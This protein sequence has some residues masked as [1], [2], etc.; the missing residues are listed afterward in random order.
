MA[1]AYKVLGQSNPSATTLTT[2]YTVPAA[3]ETVVSTITIANIS[4]SGITYRIAVRPN[5][6]SIANKHYLA[7]DATLSANSTTAYTLGMTL[8][9]GDIISVYASDTNA[10]FQAYGSEIS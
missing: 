5:G 4:A 3:T 10:V 2:L 8:D 1:T 6:E 7:Y 9:A